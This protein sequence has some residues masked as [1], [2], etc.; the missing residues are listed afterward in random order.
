MKVIQM[1]PLIKERKIIN[2]TKTFITKVKKG[3]M[4]RSTGPVALL[5]KDINHHGQVELRF[6]MDKETYMEKELPGEKDDGQ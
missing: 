5:I 2:N 4:L 6:V 3:T 1:M